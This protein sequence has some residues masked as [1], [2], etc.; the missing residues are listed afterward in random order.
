M[1]ADSYLATPE[2]RPRN[3][4]LIRGTVVMNEPSL[5][6]QRARLRLAYTFQSWVEG[7]SGR[8]E[9]G[10]PMDVRIDDDNVFS[11]DLWWLSEEHRPAPGTLRMPGVPDLVVEVRSPSTWARDLSVKL[12]GYEAAGVTE[13]WYVD[14]AARTILV[15]RRSADAR[16]FDERAE[17]GGDELLTSPMLDGF[18]VPADSIFAR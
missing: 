14:T 17:L 12:P 11:P 6:H 10:L 8:G 2:D 18:A 13:A 5:P 7:G 9:V 15:F 16:S 3:T 4:E 1:T